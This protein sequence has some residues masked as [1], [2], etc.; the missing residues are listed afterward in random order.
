M[1]K[2]TRRAFIT[3]GVLAGGALAVGVAIRPGHR[4]PKVAGQVTEEGEVLV[5]MWVK[6]D[7]SNKVTLIAPHSEMGQ[8][9][10][11]ALTQ[12]LADE[13]DARWEDT[14]FMEAP[15]I[16]EYANWALGK[17]YLI[18]DADIPE[19]LVPTIDGAMLQVAKAMKM[20]ITGGSLSIR[21][22]GVYGVRAAGA[23][24]RE[25]LINA[26]SEA[27]GV[28]PS[29][30]DAKDTH[31]VD[32]TTGKR[33]PF[34]E[35][36][37]AA[38]QTA[39][40]AS[41]VLKT[42]DQFRI[43]GK[44][45]P[46][47]DIPAKV[48]GTAV[49]G[50]DAQVSGMKHAAIMA[51]PVFGAQLVSVDA[52]KAESM[53]GVSKIVSLED[54][55][56]V[57][58][59]GY[60]QASEALKNVRVQWSQTEHDSANSESLFQQFEQNLAAAIDGGSS[61]ADVDDGDVEQALAGATAT[62]DSTYRVPYLAH[63]CMEPMNATARV[64]NDS[65]EVWIGTQNPLGFRY[66][67]A[68]AMEMDVEQVQIH[69]HP[70]G[71][72][73]GRRS[74]S[75]TAVQAAKIARAAGEPV[76]L[77]WSR[78]E[79]VRHDHYRPAVASRFRAA[80]DDNGQITGWENVYHEK[81]EPVE[82]PTI[83]YTVAAQKIHHVESPTH[84]PFGP[85]RSVDHSQH[86]FFT[87]AFFDE[88]AVAA[89]KDP[90]EYRMS[91]LGDKPRHQKVLQ[92]AAEQAGWGE[93]LPKG[94][95]RGISLQESFGSLVAQVVDVTVSKGKVSVD[96]VIVAVDA[97]FAVSPDGLTAQMES[98]VNYGLTAALYG[99]VTIEDGAVK[100]S[101]FHDYPMVRMGDS[102]VIET[103]IINSGEAW[104]GAGEPGTPGIAPALVNAVFDATGLRVRELP[105]SKQDFSDFS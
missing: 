6:I 41:P 88:V 65:C 14:A 11:N 60:W 33:A 58:A 59:D 23:A 91:L 52:S 93:T 32:T 61:K 72:G 27:W 44:S 4:A 103:H 46:R 13:L 24:A 98:G 9:A 8:G 76:K 95:G 28:P 105:L 2:W 92:T 34:A 86:G 84:V 77:I 50:I 29:Q 30:L 82:A 12:M 87:E 54:A 102:P 57:V 62:L 1:G 42:P 94:K 64:T 100:Q 18:G 48:D 99:E 3:T 47:R 89:G 96:R 37:L 78:E 21:T 5:S 63:A 97:G 83:P 104:G 49:F 7:P 67:V 40:S 55:V 69:Q 68:D 85:W 17:G 16:D 26:A 56:A 39:P 35:F 38:S 71:G 90:Y 36:A 73:F 75:D 43:M 66:E 81:H 25:L 74:N 80:L 20:Q 51:A 70:M 31:I 101:N 45:A 15:A 10:Q 79:D 53:A 19:A 22:T